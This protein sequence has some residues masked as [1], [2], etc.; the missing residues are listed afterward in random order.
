MDRKTRTFR[1]YVKKRIQYAFRGYFMGC[2]RNSACYADDTCT[3]FLLCRL[4]EKEKPRFH[5][6]TMLNHICGNQHGLGFMGIQ[7]SVWSKR[8]R[9]DWRLFSSRTK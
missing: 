5:T 2:N 9:C 8:W 7:F 6:Y 3:W 4:S 1:T